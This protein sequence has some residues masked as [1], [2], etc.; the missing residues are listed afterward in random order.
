M[1]GF[2][3]HKNVANI[4][5]LNVTHLHEEF[6]PQRVSFTGSDLRYARQNQPTADYRAAALCH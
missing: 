4:P 5:L 1:V 3:K 2:I 6:L